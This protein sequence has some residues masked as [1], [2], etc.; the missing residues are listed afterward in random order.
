M[1]NSVAAR[2]SSPHRTAVYP[3]SFDPI[4]LGHV[5]IIERVAQLFEKV[6]VLIA[7]APDKAGLFDIDERIRLIKQSLGDLKNVEV[8]VHEGLT[9][10]YLKKKKSS[11]LVRG[12]R[13]VVDFEYEVSM[14]NI[15]R[16]LAPDIETVLI[17]ASPEYYFVS[18]R[19]VKEVAVHGGA[20]NG[21][22]NEEVA[23]ALEKKLSK[24]KG[25][26]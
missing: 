23:A 5:D 20:L 6:I 26:R 2:S 18:S 1:N 14:A 7:V 22:V 25:K 12:L 9:V 11:V 4:T 17:L 15:N 13:A 19:A 16:K 24:K 8:D 10:D 21:L 3:G